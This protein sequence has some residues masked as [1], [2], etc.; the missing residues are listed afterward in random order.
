MLGFWVTKEANVSICE[1]IVPQPKNLILNITDRLLA[2][3]L[4][5]RDAHAVKRHGQVSSLGC[6]MIL[7]FNA[8]SSLGCNVSKVGPSCLT[9]KY[10]SL[11]I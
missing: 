3:I 2:G 7:R 5:I 11:G 10:I 1:Y 9:C 8:L 6:W 4:L